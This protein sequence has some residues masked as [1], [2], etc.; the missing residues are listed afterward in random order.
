MENKIG[1]IISVNKTNWNL[2]YN[3]EI[4][5]GIIN[6]SYQSETYPVVGDYVVIDIDDYL[7]CIIKSIYERKNYISKLSVDKSQKKYRKGK[8]QILASNIDIVFIVTSLNN[9][10]N[11]ARLERMV[12][13][14]LNGKTKIAFILTKSD[15]C[16]YEEKEKYKNM[17]LNRFNY[18][19]F[20]VS[21]YLNEGIEEIKSIWKVNETAVF[22]GS[23]GVGKST[24]IN[25]LIGE[26]KIKTK[27]IRCK[28]DRGRHTTTSRNLYILKDNRVVIDEPGIRSVALNDDYDLNQIFSKISELET[29]CKYTTCTHENSNGCAVIEAINNGIITLEELNR[30]KKLKLKDNRDNKRKIQK[31]KINY[32]KQ[33]K[34]NHLK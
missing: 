6:N 25:H 2:I 26:D 33:T 16:S 22:I 21:S 28:D 5:V 18:P 3:N 8:E 31:D 7:N 27:S 14:G 13:V 17:I 24:L 10:F 11:I 32:Y 4:Y 12:L 29:E 1:R 34:R 19:V 30:Y 20:I 15:L 23:S 9:D